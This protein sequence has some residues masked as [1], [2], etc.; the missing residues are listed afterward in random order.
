MFSGRELHH[1]ARH[2][3]RCGVFL[4][5]FLYKVGGFDFTVQ[6]EAATRMLDVDI[7]QQISDEV[8]F[9][10][11]VGILKTGDLEQEFVEPH[12]ATHHG[13]ALALVVVF[14]VL[15]QLFTL[16]KKECQPLFLLAC[17]LLG[18]QDVICRFNVCRV[19]NRIGVYPGL[20]IVN[21]AGRHGIGQQRGGVVRC[22]SALNI[23]VGV[24]EI[25][26][27]GFL[28]IGSAD[29][30][31]PGQRLDGIH[32]FELLQHI[33]GAELGLVETG[34]VF[35]GHQQHLIGIGVKFLRKPVFREAVQPC[36]G[37]FCLIIRQFDLAG[38]R[39]QCMDALV[40]LLGDILLER[41]AVFY[42]ALARRCDDH[43]LGLTAELVHDRGAE[44]LNDDFYALGNVRLV[45]L[46]KAGNLALGIIG[47]AA[48]VIFDFF[49]D[50]EKG[51]IFCVVLENVQNEAFL[52]GLFHGVDVE[53]LSLPV[54]IQATEKLDGG[55]LR[56]SGESEHGDVCLLAVPL[57]FTGN[58]IFHIGL[59]LLTGAQ[60]HRDSG[61]I[62][63]C[64]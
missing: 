26:H 17:D 63:A 51:R 41:L 5:L 43:C 7:R 42:G 12:K 58:H 15:Q 29:A 9:L 13:N 55:R 4:N 8:V 2:E 47:L 27:E 44:M 1:R 11:Q 49:V 62:L 18:V 31:E 52:D 56:R 59:G 37:V 22:K 21:G 20:Q 57:D 14:V 54:G 3:I 6:I 23:L 16:L 24:Y 28:V 40:S 35:I 64:S 48:R 60:R 61:H 38:E 50:L 10:M 39:H 25:Q 32:A 33:H 45:E 46:H 53:C 36:F 34:L 19:K 30:I